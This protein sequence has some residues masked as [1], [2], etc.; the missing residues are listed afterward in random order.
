MLKQ[1]PDTFKLILGFLKLNDLENFAEVNSGICKN[2]RLEINKHWAKI[3][4]NIFGISKESKE[5]RKQCVSVFNSIIPKVIEQEKNKIVFE[6]D[7]SDKI[8]SLLFSDDSVTIT[9]LMDRFIDMI[10]IYTY[11]L[12]TSIANQKY[13]IFNCDYSNKEVEFINIKKLL[14]CSFF[15]FQCYGEFVKILN[16]DILLDTYINARFKGKFKNDGK[17]TTYS[18]PTN[19]KK[20]ISSPIH[21]KFDSDKYIRE[22]YHREK[23]KKLEVKNIKCDYS[24]VDKEIS[25]MNDKGTFGLMTNIE[26][27]IVEELESCNQD[28]RGGLSDGYRVCNIENCKC[29]GCKITNGKYFIG[30]DDGFQCD[31]INFLQCIF[32]FN[33]YIVIKDADTEMYTDHDFVMTFACKNSKITSTSNHAGDVYDY[34]HFNTREYE[35]G[36]FISQD[37]I[38]NND[39]DIKLLVMDNK[40]T[41]ISTYDNI[42][43]L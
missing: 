42:V 43:I 25:L 28:C 24:N 8:K 34:L 33:K 4:P 29:E 39:M 38:G 10:V 17:L 31:L 22:K 3:N 30:D 18:L 36:S 21:A 6:L 41:I 40:L 7:I 12:G 14:A 32:D 19:L 23:S 20:S 9:P 16:D 37:T 2:S 1:A 11:V 26:K 35:A 27:I 15:H 13:Y 5:I